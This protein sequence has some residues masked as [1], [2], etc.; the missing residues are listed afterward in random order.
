MCDL[1]DALE[2]ALLTL[3]VMT[4]DNG[5]PA[6]ALPKAEL[7]GLLA[8]HPS[9]ACLPITEETDRKYHFNGDE[10]DEVWMDRP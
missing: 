4:H 7:L 9:S 3:P 2:K 8:R 5:Y 6:Q 1:H 10:A